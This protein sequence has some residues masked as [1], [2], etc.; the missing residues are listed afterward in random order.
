MPSADFA[1]GTYPIFTSGLRTVFGQAQRGAFRDARPDDLLAA[2]VRAQRKRFP[3]LWERGPEDFLAGCAYPEGEQGYNV[4]RA[5]ALGAGLPLPGLTVS[6]L[7]GSSLDAVGLAAARIASGQASRLLVGGVESMS[8]VPRRGA[9]FTE[10]EAIRAVSPQ[11]YI[12]MG[13]TAEEVARRYP[14]VSRQVQEDFA[15]L[16]HERAHAAFLAGH[17]AGQVLAPRELEGGSGAA[18]QGSGK[19]EAVAAGGDPS[20]AGGL[21]APCDEGIRYPI[22]RPRMEALKPV[23]GGLV[24]AATSSPLS[25]GAALGMVLARA[26]AEALGVKSGLEILDFAVAHVEPEVMGLGPVP[27]VHAL[28]KRNTLKATEIDAVEMNEAF[29]V[30]ALACQAELGFPLE[31]LNAWGGALAL[32]HP[33]G[34]SGLRLVMTL[35]E[36]LRILERPGAL[37]IATLCVGG[38]QGIALLGRHVRL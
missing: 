34:A 19:G 9:N 35:H 32:G 23:F 3:W 8:R 7:C 38:G 11:A 12:T 36:R 5:A 20:A 29:A 30:Q 18:F 24:T 15:A 28:L 33:L 26:E 13:E 1:R 22:D 4:A 14:S 10:S 17:Y 2:L 27:A 31:R 16:S 21:P 37:G 25:D 6:R